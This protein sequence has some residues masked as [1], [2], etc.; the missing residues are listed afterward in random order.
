MSSPPMDYDKLAEKFIDTLK[1]SNEHSPVP[2][3]TD[4]EIKSLRV[5]IKIIISLRTSA[6]TISIVIKW[7][8]KIILAAG[9]LLALLWNWKNG[10]ISSIDWHLPW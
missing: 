1:E 6:L 9:W 7:A 3:F 5:L 8:I 4:D 10:T 2:N